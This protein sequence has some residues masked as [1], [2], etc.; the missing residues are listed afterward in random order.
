MFAKLLSI[1]SINSLDSY[2]VFDVFVNL[3]SIGLNSKS[4]F[5][6]FTVKKDDNMKDALHNIIKFH[7]DRLILDT[8]ISWLLINHAP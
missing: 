2:I 1:L 8:A 4:V 6:Q 3:K 5:F 7:V